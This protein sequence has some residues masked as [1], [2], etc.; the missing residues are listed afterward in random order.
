[1][2]ETWWFRAEVEG[3]ALTHA[4]EKGGKTTL[5]GLTVSFPMGGADQPTCEECVLDTVRRDYTRVVAEHEEATQR[6][7]NESAAEDSMRRSMVDESALRLMDSVA[8]RQGR[9]NAAPV[10]CVRCHRMRPR[11]ELRKTAKG[12]A[13]RPDSP[14]YHTCQDIVQGHLSPEDCGWVVRHATL[15]TPDEYCEGDVQPGNDYCDLHQAK[16]NAMTEGSE[17][18]HE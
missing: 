3:D 18:E 13:C 14:E 7:R 1:M 12:L 10:E 5:C 8:A 15:E 17:H 6:A 11:T 4:A 2:S 9:L 16:A